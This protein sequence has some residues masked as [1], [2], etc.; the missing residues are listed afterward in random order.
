MNSVCNHCR[1]SDD[2]HTIYLLSFGSE[3]MSCSFC[4]DNW[5]WSLL[6]KTAAVF[7]ANGSATVRM[8]KREWAACWQTCSAEH[9]RCCKTTPTTLVRRSIY[10]DVQAWDSYEGE[11]DSQKFFFSFFF[12]R[13]SPQWARASSFPRFLDHTQRRTTV[14]R[15]PLD[16]WSARRRDLY[17]T[18]KT[19]TTDRHP[20]PTVGFE[21]TISAG[22]RPQTDALD[23]AAN[24]EKNA[25]TKNIWGF[26]GCGDFYR[27][28]LI[29][30]LSDL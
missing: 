6:H 17:L 15:T 13:H 18:T 7:P 20:Y 29:V 22:E 30:T 27:V 2:K 26:S 28:F 8:S 24:V 25:F 1:W 5:R 16:K 10:C 9:L 23:R 14:G 11:S 21:P 19:R 3:L 4:D 12:G